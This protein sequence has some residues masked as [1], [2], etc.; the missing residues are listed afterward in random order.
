MTAMTSKRSEVI[1]VIG[2]LVIDAV[3]S[4]VQCPPVSCQDPEGGHCLVFI[5]EVP[6]TQHQV[7]AYSG[8]PTDQ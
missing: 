5:S 6:Q 7:E 8:S 3:L 1:P 4:M 2:Q